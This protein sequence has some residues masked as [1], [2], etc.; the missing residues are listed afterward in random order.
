MRA[1]IRYGSKGAVQPGHDGG[2]DGSDS[3][4]E[5]NGNIHD[6]R[7]LHAGEGKSLQLPYRKLLRGLH[8]VFLSGTGLPR[9]AA[10]NN[11]HDQQAEV[12]PAGPLVLAEGAGAEGREIPPCPGHRGARPVQKSGKE[13]LPGDLRSGYQASGS[14]R[15]RADADSGI[16]GMDG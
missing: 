16:P 14:E 3:G 5:R 8:P 6:R 10:E 4:N 1:G 7:K 11:V 15:Q 12:Q 13:L 2:T 9:N